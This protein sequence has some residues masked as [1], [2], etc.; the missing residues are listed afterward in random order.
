VQI[1]YIG[2]LFSAI[3]CVY[4]S[5]RKKRIKR[6]K[7]APNKVS[8]TIFTTILNDLRHSLLGNASAIVYYLFDLTLT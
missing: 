2:P 4:V 5:Q 3:T 1:G 8:G 6:G 7:A